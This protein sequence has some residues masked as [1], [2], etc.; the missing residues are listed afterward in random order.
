MRVVAGAPIP[1]SLTAQGVKGKAKQEAHFLRFRAEV[2][3]R[4]RA[5]GDEDAN[6]W[7]D[8]RKLAKAMFGEGVLLPKRK[9]EEHHRLNLSRAQLRQLAEDPETVAKRIAELRADGTLPKGGLGAKHTAQL[10]ARAAKE[11]LK[12]GKGAVLTVA[13]VNDDFTDRKTNLP[14]IRAGVMLVQEAKNTNIRRE[15]GSH[16]GVHQ[17][18]RRDDRAGSA[19]VWNKKRVDVTDRGYSLAVEPRGAGMLRRWMS[20]TDMKVDGATVRMISVHRPPKRF[21]HLWPQFDANLAR[22]VKQTKGPVV[23]GLDA[24][25]RNPRALAKATGL[26]WVAP[27]GSIDGFLVSPGVKIEKVWRLPKGSS[28]HHPVLARIRLPPAK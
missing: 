2:V 24:N 15:L 25:E 3:E 1:A 5:N 18:T 6:G 26:K 4:L 12:A 16:R 11:G 23:I 9:G 13:T 28:D 14:R 27:Q 17:D 7:A 8:F 22:F 19:V 10:Y 21:S 20:W